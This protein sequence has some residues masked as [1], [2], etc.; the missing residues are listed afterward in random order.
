MPS[1]RQPKIDDSAFPIR[2]L[3]L[4]P[5]QGFASLGPGHD[6]HRWLMRHISAGEFAW[7][8]GGRNP[9]FMQDHVAVYFRTIE[10]ASLFLRSTQ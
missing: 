8:S 3:V 6:P 4:V 9:Y 1:T 7:H 5:E 2:I 10:A